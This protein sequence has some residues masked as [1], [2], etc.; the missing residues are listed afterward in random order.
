[1]PG[2]RPELPAPALS[3]A[4]ATARQGS[5]ASR[6]EQS[7]APAPAAARRVRR[8]GCGGPICTLCGCWRLLS[9]GP[10]DAVRAGSP[11]PVSRVPLSLRLQPSLAPRSLPAVCLPWDA[12]AAPSPSA[13]LVQRHLRWLTGG[14]HEAFWPWRTW[15]PHTRVH[16]RTHM[17]THSHTHS[18]THMQSHAQ[19]RTH[20]HALTFT[21]KQPH[22]VTCTHTH[23]HT[24]TY[25]VAHTVTRTCSHMHTHAHTLTCICTKH[26][27][28]Q[29]HTQSHVH[30]HAHP[31]THTHSHTCTHSHVHTPPPRTHK[32]MRTCVLE[33]ESQTSL[34]STPGR[35]KLFF[36]GPVLAAP[37]WTRSPS[38]ENVPAGLGPSLPHSGQV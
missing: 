30:T 4:P 13:Y 26:L 22:T 34:Q 23:V 33:S 28:A 8:C 32:R 25:T 17:H 36:Q 7:A 35:E 24:C 6:G 29:S 31:P 19:T 38:G 21:C 18:H 1:M 3:R 15:G 16:T 12:H 11:L 14:T 5:G 20:M 27:H 9:Q 37:C 2:W 10:A